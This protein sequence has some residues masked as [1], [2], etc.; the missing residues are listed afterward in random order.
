MRSIKNLLLIILLTFAFS[1]CNENAFLEEKPLSIYTPENSLVTA[2]DYQSA[3]NYLYNR[4]RY[5]LFD[6]GTA[7]NGR[8]ALMYGTDMA[9]MA[10]TTGLLNTYKTYML[11]T[12]GEPLNVWRYTY[13]IINQANLI[14]TRIENTNFDNEIKNKHRGQA[15]C[16]RAFGYKLLANLF[17]GVPIFLEESA[18]IRRDAVRAT[19]EEVYDQCKTDLTEA[20]SLLDNIDDVRGGEVSKQVA[21]HY[22]CEIYICLGNNEEAIKA[23]T[24]VIDYPAMALMTN[25]FGT[26]ADKQG[27]PFSD[28]FKYNNQNRCSGNTES[29]W[30]SQ[31]DYLNPSSTSTYRD[32]HAFC[33]LPRYWSNTING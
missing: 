6:L 11:P 4:V 27:S 33:F 12:A 8:Y 32:R 5:L 2:S 30:V 24:E 9:Y 21:Q 3:V 20:I 13:M 14:L 31:F 25:R 19:R 29:L 23:A 15:L 18:G 22:L 16:I 17:G 10:Y 1:N 7:Q 26:F 28:L